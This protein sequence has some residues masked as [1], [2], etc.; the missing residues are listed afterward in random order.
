MDI[1]YTCNGICFIWNKDKAKINISKHGGISFEQASTAFFDPFLQVIDASRNNE[2]RD[3]LIGMD[4]KWS[5]LYVVHLQ[6]E[7]DEIRIISA[8]KA[9]KKERV[10]YES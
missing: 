3:A 6:I 10:S 2:M 4:D 8:R 1:K 5:V 7:N 9:T